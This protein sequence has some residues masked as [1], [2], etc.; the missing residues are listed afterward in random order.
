MMTQSIVPAFF[1]IS[2]ALALTGCESRTIPT[3]DGRIPQ[4]YLGMAT[5]FLGRYAARGDFPFGVNRGEVQLVMEGTRLVL[6]SDV[7][8]LGEGCRSVIGPLKSIQVETDSGGRLTAMDG[9]FGFGA[10][11]CLAQG[12]DIIFHWNRTL[13]GTHAFELDILIE[14][15]IS[16]P[17]GLVRGEIRTWY[18]T[19]RS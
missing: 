4:P 6:S 1:I 13:V 5:P 2:G 11:R 18:L 19:P 7:D 9:D 15:P 17:H 10:E 8:L 12:R 3:P 16:E 14:R